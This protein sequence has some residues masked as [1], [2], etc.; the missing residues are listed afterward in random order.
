MWQG[1][2]KSPFFTALLL[3]TNIDAA[4]VSPKDRHRFILKKEHDI[5]WQGNIFGKHNLSVKMLHQQR[6]YNY[7]YYYL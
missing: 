5:I 6:L 4:T 3:S 1:A 7:Y 2:E